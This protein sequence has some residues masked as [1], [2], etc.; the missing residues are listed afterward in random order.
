MPATGAF[1]SSDVRADRGCS[2]WGSWHD[3]RH[4]GHHC[5]DDDDDD[6]DYFDFVHHRNF[7]NV[8]I[9]LVDVP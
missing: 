6:R 1:A 9:I 3:G 8:L 4:H 7:D 2:D 5:D